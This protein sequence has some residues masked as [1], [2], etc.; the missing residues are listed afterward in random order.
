MSNKD[1]NILTQK[2]VRFRRRYMLFE[3]A[4]GVILFLVSFI[5][6]FLFV[7]YLEYRLYLSTS[8][9]KAIFIGSL[10]FYTLLFFRF[11]GLRLLQ[12]LG[13]F[14]V[15]DYF[16]VAGII[17]GYFP[18]LGDRLV[19]I[20]ELG[21]E[22]NSTYSESLRK[23]AIAQKV[24]QVRAI[25]FNSAIGIK[26]LY[27]VIKY[28]AFSFLLTVVIM[29]FNKESFFDS[30][31]RLIHFNETFEKP[32]PFRYMWNNEVKGIL[33]GSDFEVEVVTE[34]EQIP[35]LLYINIGGNNFLMTAKGSG[36][37]TYNLNSVINSIPFYFT[38]L[39]FR[40]VRYMLDVIP[41]PVLNNFTV[42][43]DP[44]LYT[45]LPSYVS[46]NIGDF[47]VP[48]G[49]KME[50]L[51]SAF[52]T[53]S[54]RVVSLDEKFS[55]ESSD[56]KSGYSFSRIIDSSIQYSVELKN[57]YSEYEPFIRISVQVIEDLYPEITVAQAIDS[58]QLSRY[59]FKGSINDDYGF[60]QLAFHLSYAD[61]DSVIYLPF[62]RNLKPQDFYFSF[63]F[64][65]INPSRSPVQYF[66]SVSD[67][68]AYS[69]SKTTFSGSQLFVFPDR[70]NLNEAE[71]LAYQKIEELIGESHQLARELKEDVRNMQMKNLNSNL[72][73]WERTQMAEEML[74]K[75]NALEDILGEIEETYNQLTN[76]QNSFTQ[77]RSDII[78]KQK[79]IQELLDSVI[80]D[81]IRSL[82]DEFNELA[83][84][85]NEQRLNDLSQ[86]M[87]LSF[88]SLSRQLDRNLEM[89]KRMRI[90]QNVLGIAE[91]L[92]TTGD[93]LERLSDQLQNSGFSDEWNES[94]TDQGYQFELLKQEFLQI[95]EQN[96]ELSRPFELNEVKDSFDEIQNYLNRHLETPNRTNKNQTREQTRNAGDQM[97]KLA[98]RI[99][100]IM[101]QAS[102]LQQGEDIANLQ[103]ILRNLLRFSFEQERILTSMA[104]L[105]SRDPLFIDL[106]RSQRSLIGQNSVIQDS[107][108][109]LA[110]RVPQINN[111]VSN[112]LLSLSSN[113]NRSLAVLADDNYAQ[114]MV[115]QQLVFTAA[116]NLTLLLS[117]I[118][119]NIE[120][121]RFGDGEGEGD[122]NSGRQGMNMLQQQSENL[123]EQLQR[124]LNQ[125]RDG[126]QPMSRELSESLMMQEMM[127]QFLR[128][129]VNTGGV[130]EDSRR[131][132]QEIDRLLEL[133]RQDILNRQISPELINRQSEIL[134]R[135]LEAERSERERDEEN[136]R[137]SNTA[138]ELFYSNPALFF[139]RNENEDIMLE[140]LQRNGLKVNQFYLMKMNRFIERW[141]AD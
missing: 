27:R 35:S 128:E 54:I 9:R 94:V 102:M 132:L 32:A 11:I 90:E 123:K 84:S 124:M 109:A 53:D 140:E 111:V 3:L 62:H 21:K 88:E 95:L 55:L 48:K 101:E 137:E 1:L 20:L 125:M 99:E 75:R 33:K 31:F 126:G 57:E 129:L 2:L 8:W 139:E 12:L 87:D 59:F 28:F 16:K 68:D 106:I 51:F 47:T 56:N 119:E 58:L 113:L 13:I 50:L 135:L 91:E 83:K 34:G 44:P 5:L 18:H 116:N 74:Q 6:V 134:S 42:R 19:N 138:E 30:G 22:D 63:N 89:L 77:Q 80:T 71:M 66:F 69:G 61:V 96:N 4:K 79:L 41:V 108:Y 78:E 86:Q 7:N 17:T 110:N 93:N 39:Q 38:D 37:F 45:S 46:E 60:S 141:S 121:Q 97:K 92:R 130:G 81:E 120:N 65:D 115:H 104:A 127:Q 117:D 64:A 25:D 114:S 118:L 133:S 43:V 10:S 103:Q 24:N 131:Q 112:E 49:S 29:L 85:F 15:I 136:K 52:D 100:S 67:N 70:S 36:R 82:L 23:A 76:F 98:Q 14:Q 107:L 122:G 72:S 105:P 73:E 26:N 40:S